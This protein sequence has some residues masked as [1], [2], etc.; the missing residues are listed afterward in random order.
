VQVAGSLATYLPAVP[1]ATAIPAAAV[2]AERGCGVVFF[3]DDDPEDAVVITVQG[4][5]PPAAPVASTIQDADADTYVRTEQSA[6]E[7]KVRIGVGGTERGRWQTGSPHVQF[8]GDLLQGGGNAAF[9]GASVNSDKLVDVGGGATYTQ[10]MGLHIGLGSNAGPS[11][12][13]VI[14]IGGYA[15]AKTTGDVAA[16]GLDFFAGFANVSGTDAIAIRT[17]GLLQGSGYTITN[18]YSHRHNNPTLIFATLT[19]AYKDYYPALNAGTNRRNV[20]MEDISGGTIA[21]FV[22]YASAFIVK[23]TGEYT[24]AA[25]QTPVFIYE[26]TTPTLRQVQWKD[27]AAVGG[28]DRVMVLV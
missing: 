19:N 27:G 28:G 13:Q 26:G 11:P 21:R 4:A 15:L 20:Y 7:D 8:T 12:G 16:I 24:R 17:G 3:T 1:V 23:G 6:D 18:F 22:E 10:K 5:L 25:N 14:G 2:V 9:A